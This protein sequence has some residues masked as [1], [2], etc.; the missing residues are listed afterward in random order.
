LKKAERTEKPGRL[1]QFLPGKKSHTI[2]RKIR[3][4]RHVKST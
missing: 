2:L 1:S 3:K 4:I